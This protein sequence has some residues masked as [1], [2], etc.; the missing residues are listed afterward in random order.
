MCRDGPRPAPGGAAQACPDAAPEPFRSGPGRA[1]SAFGCA[2]TAHRST[3][4][5]R[6]A[7]IW[8]PYVVT[9]RLRRLYQPPELS[10][11]L[12]AVAGI[13]ETSGW[14]QVA[15][16]RE[17]VDRHHAYIE[18]PN[19]AVAW[20]KVE[21]TSKYHTGQ[22]ILA[23]D[24]RIEPAPENL[25]REDPFI[26]VVRIKDPDITVLEFA[27]HPRIVPTNGAPYEVGHTVEALSTGVLR[28]LDTKPISLID[29]PEISD[30]AVDEF[31]VK[32]MTNIGE[33]DDFGGLPDVVQRARMLV[34]TPLKYSEQLLRIGAPITKGVLFIGPPGTGKT[35][36]AR[37]IA[38][39][40]KAEFYQINGPQVV[41]K[42]LGQTEQL[43]RRIFD[44]A[45][46]STSGA[47]I[48]FD[49]IDSIAEERSQESHEASRRMVAQLLT[50]MDSRS[51]N[52]KSN[53]IVIGAT[54]RPN[55]IDPALRRPGRFDWEIVFPLPDKDGREQILRA[56]GKKLRLAT[57]VP[58]PWIAE[59]TDSWTPA[60]L[61]AIWGEAAML[62]VMDGR[63]TIM[64][65]DCIGGFQ[66]V[67]RIR[68]HTSGGAA[69]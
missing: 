28:I 21:N 52:A 20:V 47:V 9:G 22:I 56:S 37:I 4:G 10:A 51:R 29:F 15:R 50:L 36:L 5:A 12:I 14:G 58:Y 11:T 8:L 6:V 48:F 13:L 18:M 55:A 66:W 25:W 31:T 17:I 23:F 49:E 7:T 63:D 42:W 34:E 32:D 65:E 26:S 38:R 16:I 30:D 68:K 33:L 61:T 35:M 46:Q 53:V 43:L 3:L 57:D 69:S 60:D 59:Q 39:D 2:V 1:N 24:D 67:G 54:N 19:G 40:S 44:H 62:A 41:S 45:S 64:A 27:G